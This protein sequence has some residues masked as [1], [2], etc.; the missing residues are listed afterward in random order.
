MPTTAHYISP[1][2]LR[3]QLNDNAEIALLDVR[4][5]GQYGEGHAFFSCNIPYSRLELDVPRLIPRRDTRIILV[6]ADDGVAELAY[7][8]LGAAGYSRTAILRGGAKAWLKSGCALFKGVNVP[9]KTFGE[10]VERLCHTPQIPADE[11][12]R[13]LESGKPVLLVDGRTPAEHKK[14]TIPGA[15]PVPNG[16]LPLRLPALI[17]DSNTPIVIHCAGRTR[18]IIGAQTL[19]HLGVKNPVTAL[20]NGTQGWRLAGLK[21]EHGSPRTLLATGSSDL[22]EPARQ[23]AF[24]SG[25]EE[26]DP[27]TAQ[28][29]I[30]D[31]SR[32]TYVF[33][34][35]SQEEY[36]DKSIP[37]A[38]HAPGG[39]LIQTTDHYIAVRHA[40]ILILDDEGIRAPT[41]SA[42]LRQLG[43]KA[44]T[45]QGGIH[46]PLRIE[47]PKWPN[48]SFAPKRIAAETLLKL[49]NDKKDIQ[50]ID[51]RP[52]LAYREKHVIGAIWSIRPKI[53]RNIRTGTVLLISA[54]ESLAALSTA[55]LHDYGI[56]E[57][58]FADW[59]TCLA[60]GLPLT[61]TPNTPSNDEAIDYLF[62]VHDRHDGNLEAARRYIEWETGL[63]SQ[64]QADELDTFSPLAHDGPSLSSHTR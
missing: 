34:I 21:L 40:Q 44:V 20:E 8:R 50:I 58:L 38:I 31:R 47:S 56:S 33:D 57:I 7:A 59:E 49:Y 29:W 55:D 25:A 13:H 51:L 26:I 52:S 16:E 22:R 17:D 5:P 2:D 4:E 64:C 23:F 60:A 41:V 39:Q 28:K 6:D 15:L 9:S 54:D 46:A 11:L 18:S 14:M 30:D 45:V 35:R 3:T 36:R 19:R 12:H 48:L 37:G 1:T 27:P 63:V 24:R 32:T 43:H 42:W 53:L 10:L 62:F 61:T